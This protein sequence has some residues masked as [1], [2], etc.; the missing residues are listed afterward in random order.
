MI[1]KVLVP[2]DMV[3]EHDSRAAGVIRRILALDEQTVS[4]TLVET[5]A[6]FAGRHRDL[7]QT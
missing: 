2:G 4:A 5:T 7:E 3:P 1:T 6:R